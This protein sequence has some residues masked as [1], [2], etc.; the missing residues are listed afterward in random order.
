M[1]GE[2]M[3][4]GSVEFSILKDEICKHENALQEKG[5]GEIQFHLQ[6]VWRSAYVRTRGAVQAV[7]VHSPS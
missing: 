4:E 2:R 5:K 7:R 3:G 6:R 1:G